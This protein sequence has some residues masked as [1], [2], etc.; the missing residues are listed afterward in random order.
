[1]KNQ[2]KKIVWQN[3]LKSKQAE[4]SFGTVI[5]VVISVV[6]SAAL[7]IGLIPLY[8]STFFGNMTQRTGQVYDA[9]D[10]D[11]V[12][13]NDL[14]GNSMAYQGT[15]KENYET[16]QHNFNLL[17]AGESAPSEF[18]YGDYKYSYD[19]EK[20]GWAVSLNTDYTGL[21]SKTGKTVVQTDKL[22]SSYG[23]ILSDA[24]GYQVRGMDSLFRDCV[25]ICS[26]D[27]FVIPNH[28]TSMEYT[29]FGCTGLTSLDGL[30]IP[31]SVTDMNNTFQNCASLTTA[32]AIPGSVTN[33]QQTFYNCTSLTG[34][35]T[36]NANPTVYSS[37]L[38]GTTQPITL[39]GSSTK[40][41]QIA[42]TAN[43]SNVTVG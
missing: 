17:T 37:C 14:P 27:W 13:A 18:Y 42:A 33:M 11:A 41:T 22:Q 31:N 7:I 35:I 1:M 10:V 39:T 38:S 16:F 30:T 34:T 2:R 36:I 8:Q 32:P 6:L 26:L 3:R 19:S 20:Y 5:R 25:N 4:A 40:L 43:N 21:E 29:L 15:V 9:G 24:F 23:M 28:A 12:Q